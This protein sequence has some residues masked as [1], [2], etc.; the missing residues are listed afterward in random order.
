ME[1]L[2]G[3]NNYLNYT[4]KINWIKDLEGGLRS[5]SD[6]RSLL[7]CVGIVDDFYHADIIRSRGILSWRRGMK[8]RKALVGILSSMLVLSACSFSNTNEYDTE[9]VSDN[10]VSTES[11]S[12]ERNDESTAEITQNE[13]EF[14]EIDTTK[15]IED[16]SFDIQLTEASWKDGYTIVL[17]A[18]REEAEK[19]SKDGLYWDSFDEIPAIPNVEDTIIEMEFYIQFGP[20]AFMLK[21]LDGNEIPEL[22]ICRATEEFDSGV[23]YQIFTWHDG[24]TIELLGNLGYRNGICTICQDNLLKVESSGTATDYGNTIYYLPANSTELKV[25]EQFFAIQ[26]KEDSTKSDFFWFSSDGEKTPITEDKYLD[27]EQNYVEQ[28]DLRYIEGTQ[29]NIAHISDLWDE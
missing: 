5:Y 3:I 7:L 22:F 9:V 4:K 28:A 23:I 12:E 19:I 27:Y 8:R 15:I 10:E 24:K 1:E 13:D 14:V 18:Y 25:V 16:Q 17:N 20:F 6:C 21:D 11:T 2:L 26:N 29:D